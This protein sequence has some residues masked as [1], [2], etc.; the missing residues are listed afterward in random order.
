MT[1]C[2][3]YRLPGDHIKGTIEEIGNHII[4]GMYVLHNY[5][6]GIGCR[7]VGDSLFVDILV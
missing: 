6:N 5:W 4:L 7:R 3:S 1:V 2:M